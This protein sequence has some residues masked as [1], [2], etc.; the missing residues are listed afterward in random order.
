MTVLDR[1]RRNRRGAAIPE[2]ALLLPIYIVLLL[3]FFELGFVALY[4]S[5][6]SS[7]SDAVARYLRD[8]RVQKLIPTTVGMRDAAC[9]APKLVSISCD[10]AVMKIALYDATN[11]VSNP[12]TPPV[13]IDNLAPAV[14]TNDAY[15]VAMGYEWSSPWPTARLILPTSGGRTQVQ[16]FNYALLAERPMD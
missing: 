5:S 9:N 10:A 7:A 6:M 15:N 14:L 16:I 3:M 11:L 13:I 4:Q 2:F 1:V 8:Q 12:V